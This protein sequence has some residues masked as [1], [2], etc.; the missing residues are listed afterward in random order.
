MSCPEGKYI[1]G[2]T[3]EVIIRKQ[4]ENGVVRSMRITGQEVKKWA[5]GCDG[6]ATYG[7][8]HGYLFPEVKWEFMKFEKENN[9]GTF[10]DYQKECAKY[11]KY[12]VIGEKFVYPVLGLGDEAGEVLGKVKKLFRD[13]GGVVTDNFKD[14]IKKELGDVLWYLAQCCTE[15][16]LSLEDVARTN[17]NKLDDRVQRGKLQGSGDDR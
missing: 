16:D 4:D 6:L 15:F 11:A 13:E 7:H 1:H 12:P 3:V 8:V 2:E 10:K 14:K 5:E 9:L 17:I